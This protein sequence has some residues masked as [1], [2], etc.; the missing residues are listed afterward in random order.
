L[1]RYVAR[2]CEHHPTYA[3]KRGIWLSANRKNRWLRAPDLNLRLLRLLSAVLK[4]ENVRDP[5]LE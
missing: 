5:Q 2:T 1:P 3:A 4:A